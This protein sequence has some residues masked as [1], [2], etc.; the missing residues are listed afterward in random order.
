MNISIANGKKAF[1]NYTPQ[2]LP[3]WHTD[4]RIITKLH[5]PFLSNGTFTKT[6]KTSSFSQKINWLN[7]SF[8]HKTYG[9]GSL[10]KFPCLS[11]VLAAEQSQSQDFATAD[12][13]GVGFG[14]LPRD[15]PAGQTADTVLLVPET[16]HR[17]HTGAQSI[18]PS[19]HIHFRLRCCPWHILWGW[20]HHVEQQLS[21]YLCLASQRQI[22]HTYRHQSSHIQI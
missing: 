3:F 17:N 21:I 7:S 2:I 18:H 14:V 8:D 1:D 22:G 11:P 9:N 13:A 5:G 19:I 4:P 6:S 20:H 16:K 12:T 15:V 10:W